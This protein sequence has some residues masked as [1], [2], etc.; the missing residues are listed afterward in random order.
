[1]RKR[2]QSLSSLWKTDVRTDR[3]KGRMTAGRPLQD[4]PEM[5]RYLISAKKGGHGANPVRRKSKFQ[6]V[7]SS[8]PELPSRWRVDSRIS[9]SSETVVARSMAIRVGLKLG[10]PLKMGVAA[11]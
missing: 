7:Y 3:I 4:L 10:I 5:R 8:G 9:V 2:A 6:R 1:M 11:R